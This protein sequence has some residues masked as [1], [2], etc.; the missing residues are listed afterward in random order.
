MKKVL[1]SVLLF[2]LMFFVASC[3][4]DESTTEPVIT[5]GTILINSQP[6]GAEIWLDG[7]NTGEVTQ[8]T[9]DAEEGVHTITLKF[10]DYEDLEFQ[11]SVIAG[12]ESIVTEN[13]LVPLYTT[14]STPVKI[15]ET[16]GTTAEQPSGL[17]LSSGNAYGTSDATNRGNI[18]LYYYSSSDGSTFLVQS[19]HL[20]ANM[21]RETFFM[22]SSGTSLTDGEDSPVKDNSWTY[23]MSDREDNY[24]FLY[25][26]DGHY[27]KL[28]I[29]SFG[30][31]TGPGDPSWVEVEWIYNKVQ[32][33]IL[34]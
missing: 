7:V 9:I 3:D 19:S 10:N 20:N 15:W 32:H 14:F 25:D 2:G 23:T 31:G 12:E 11:V 16:T 29:S 1:L 22:V 26:A 24:V 27:S 8:A 13:S 5:A 21:S 28:K 4:D 33:N 18:D 17:D 34:F 30:G 6:Q